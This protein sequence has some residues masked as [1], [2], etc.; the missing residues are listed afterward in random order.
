MNWHNII[1]QLVETTPEP[2]PTACQ[3]ITK[4]DTGLPVS[5]LTNPIYEGNYQNA[6]PPPPQPLPTEGFLAKLR[7]KVSDPAD[8][9]SKLE[10]TLASLTAIPEMGMRVTAAVGV[11]K[12]T[13]SL[14]LDQLQACYRYRLNVLEQ[15]ATQFSSALNSQQANEVTTREAAVAQATTDIEQHS[16]AIQDLSAKRETLNAEIITAKTKL[17]AA[18][19]GFTAAATALKQ[20]LTEAANRLTITGVQQ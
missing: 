12:A 8:P 3:P 9:V 15:Q 1:D 5:P 6:V 14:P 4:A 17:A 20:E 16:R 18:Q 11:L 13:A 19:A 7:A 2:T 10:A